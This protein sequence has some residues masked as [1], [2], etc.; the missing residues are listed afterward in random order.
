VLRELHYEPKSAAERAAIDRF[1]ARS[2]VIFGR[3][4]DKLRRGAPNARLVYFPNAG[5][6]VYMT[7]EA[8]VL[9][10]IHA[11]IAGLAPPE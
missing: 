5:H 6:Y 8:D 9:R 1:V 2:A 3:W 7:K 10:E 11:F 4:S